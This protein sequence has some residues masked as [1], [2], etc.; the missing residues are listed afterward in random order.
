MSVVSV[1]ESELSV[2]FQ[3]QSDTTQTLISPLDLS[4]HPIPHRI[5]NRF[6]QPLMELG[7]RAQ[8]V[9]PVEDGTL[10]LVAGCQEKVGCSTMALTLA[11]ASA[12]EAPSALVDADLRTRGLT[13]LLRDRDSAGWDDV[14][15]GLSSIQQ[16]THY[17][18]SREALAFFPI[19]ASSDIP[20]LNNHQG[21]AGWL[22]QLRQDYRLVF[23]DGGSVLDRAIEWAPWVDTVLIVRDPTRSTDTEW[24]NAW[25]RFEE[26]GAHVLGIVETFA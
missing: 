14:I 7:R 21:L 10:V 3:P 20:L 17:V 11:A 23:L 18:D 15:S 5:L 24:R 8:R 6:T 19:R 4:V 12:A 25:D 22:A 26:R 1:P 9:G 16:A 13:Q 2:A